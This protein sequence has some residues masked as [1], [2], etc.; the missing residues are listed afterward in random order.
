[1]LI[2]P[3]FVAFAIAAVAFPAGIY[4]LIVDWR[5]ERSRRRHL[6]KVRGP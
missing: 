3:A 6:A 5:A 4:Y 2:T 1:M